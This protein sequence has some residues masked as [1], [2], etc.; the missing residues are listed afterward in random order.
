ML[1]AHDAEGRDVIDIAAT[2]VLHARRILARLTDTRA[3]YVA[4][5][6]AATPRVWRL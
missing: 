5:L 2:A 3:P 4:Q 1:F 6:H